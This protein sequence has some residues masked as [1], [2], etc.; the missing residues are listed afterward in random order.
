MKI[1]GLLLKR[2]QH[3]SNHHKESIPYR[4][5]RKPAREESSLDPPCVYLLQLFLSTQNFGS[6]KFKI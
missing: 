3:H 6:A 2:V 4:Q 1:A 5:N